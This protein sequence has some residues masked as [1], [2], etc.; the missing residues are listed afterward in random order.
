[1]DTIYSRN[2]ERARAL[3]VEGAVGMAVQGLGWYLRQFPYQHHFLVSESGSFVI[4]TGL[5][6]RQRVAQVY[7]RLPKKRCRAKTNTIADDSVCTQPLSW[8][9]SGHEFDIGQQC[10]STFGVLETPPPFDPCD[11]VVPPVLRWMWERN[12]QGSCSLRLGCGE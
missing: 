9:P 6:S 4:T 8:C 10:L 11:Q 2:H 5:L 7:R 3:M 1:M 12:T